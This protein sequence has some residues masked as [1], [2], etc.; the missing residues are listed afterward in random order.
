MTRFDGCG[1]MIGGRWSLELSDF[2]IETDLSTR[3][4]GSKQ[5]KA[6]KSEF[7]RIATPKGS[8]QTASSQS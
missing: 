8:P 5:Q 6:L 3:V 1:R 4:T 7:W 2:K